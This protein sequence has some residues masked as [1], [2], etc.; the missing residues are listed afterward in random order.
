M[1]KKFLSTKLNNNVIIY[2]YETCGKDPFITDPI[3]ISAVCMDINTLELKSDAEGKPLIFTTLVKLPKDAV[4][5]EM[6]LKK[7]NITLAELEEKGV[8]QAFAFNQFAS[9]CRS[10]ARSD[11]KWDQPYSS[12]FNISNFDDIISH[13]LCVRHGHV[14]KDGDSL[15]FHPFHKFDLLDYIRIF[16]CWSDTI[17]AYNLDAVRDE[18]G[19]D[20]TG[21]HRAEKDVLDS[22]LLLKRFMNYFKQTSVKMLPKFKGAFTNEA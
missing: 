11:R 22:Y 16:Y 15:L 7:N 21:S 19:I 20:K 3:E 4:V 13:R 18:F 6:A 2:D 14:D 8:D 12:G 5:E 1:K 9:Y 10:F 17:P